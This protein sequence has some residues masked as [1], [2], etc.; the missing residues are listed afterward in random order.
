MAG[1]GFTLQ[2]LARRETL[3]A[4]FAAYALSAIVSVGPWLFT[5]IA[6]AGINLATVSSTGLSALAQMRIIIIYNF[7]I[8]LVFSGPIAMIATRLLADGLYAKDVRNAPAALLVALALALVTQAPIAIFI[9]FFYAEM[10]DALRFISVAN[11]LIVAALW[12][13]AVFLSALK[14]YMSVAIS[15]AVGLILAF[16]LALALSGLG[17]A[18]LLAGFTI[19]LGVTLFAL[20]ARAFAEYPY[21]IT[22][23]GNLFEYFRKYPEIALSGLIYNAAIWAD[24][25][26]MWCAPEA[27]VPKS[28]LVSY[29]AYDGAMFSA[30]LTMVPA[31]AMFVFAVET[32]FFA[33]YRRFYRAIERHGTLSKISEAHASI[34]TTL[35]NSATNLGAL[36]I[37]IALFVI[38]LSP[39]LL[40]LLDLH[41]SQLGMFRLGVLG[42]AFHALFLFLSIVM[43]YFDL[44]RAVLLMQLLFLTLNAV[45]TA[46]TVQL[47]F[48]WYGYG[49]FAA[50]L[51]SAAVAALIATDA[52]ARLPYLT[53]VLNNPALKRR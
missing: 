13:A 32:K 8:S 28:G 48:A 30:Q 50:A 36:Q 23:A 35:S 4:S 18:G 38:V 34:I 5:V 14:D 20:I 7:A 24:K 26:V 27:V 52:V 45:G 12:V 1:V 3:S 33:D 46:L 43:A 37:S 31:L 21:T 11:F 51:I 53:F 15:F 19:G 6:V 10:S 49:Y 25:W 22:G 39:S 42:A 44:R 16:A 40:S 41:A 2:N 29:P 47:G 9:Y 17:P